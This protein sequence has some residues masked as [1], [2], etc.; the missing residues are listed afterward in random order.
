MRDVFGDKVADRV[1]E[2]LNVVTAETSAPTESGKRIEFI[3]LSDVVPKNIEWFWPN[4][5]PRGQ[6]ITATGQPFVGKSL[7]LLDL[8]ACFTTGGW[9]PDDTECPD[10]E[11]ILLTAEDALDSTIVPRLLACGA[12]RARICVLKKIKV[13]DKTQRRFLLSED[14]ELLKQEVI[15]RPRTLMIGI[16][17]ITSYVGSKLDSHKMTDMRNVLEPLNELAEATNTLVVSITHPPKTSQNAINAYIG[18]AAFVAVPR[19]G[20]LLAKEIQD[21]R[22]TGKCLLTMVGTNIGAMMPTLRYEILPVTA[23]DRRTDKKFETA[24]IYWE[25]ESIDMTAD[26]VLRSGR[27]ERGESKIA[28]VMFLQ[29]ALQNG[30][31][32]QKDLEAEAARMGINERTLRRAFKDIGHAKKIGFRDT[33]WEWR[34][35]EAVDRP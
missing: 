5:I 33:W 2:W 20:Y 28:A 18:S 23:P 26:E 15:K 3:R 35:K 30:P 32:P 14:L 4:R 12:N 8:A 11:V 16:D 22:P 27:H 19:I 10:G 1:A 13:D 7:W 34:L 29:M 6:H 17:P 9:F 21:D 25:K 24:R 31:R